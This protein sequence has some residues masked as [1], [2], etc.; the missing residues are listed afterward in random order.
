MTV[1]VSD[2]NVTGVTFTAMAV[3]RYMIT[4]QFTGLAA[5]DILVTISGPPPLQTTSTCYSPG[6]FHFTGM[7]EGLYTVSASVPN[8]SVSPLQYIFT[9]AS[10]EGS[11]RFDVY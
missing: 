11:C 5:T 1:T 4:V 6:T 8:H 2:A 9:L 3:P 10:S 7:P